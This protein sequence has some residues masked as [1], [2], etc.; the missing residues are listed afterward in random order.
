M[1]TINLLFY[2]SS[3]KSIIHN[4]KL[5]H[6]PKSIKKASKGKRIF[7]KKFLKIEAA[8]TKKYTKIVNNA[9]N[10]S[11]MGI[12]RVERW[13]GWDYIFGDFFGRHKCVTIMFHTPMK[14]PITSKKMTLRYFGHSFVRKY[15]KEIQMIAILPFHF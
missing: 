1:Q 8:L 10:Q 13:R 12:V 14:H 15:L 5:K 2:V 7:Y 11:K 3:M 6:N 4:R 9:L